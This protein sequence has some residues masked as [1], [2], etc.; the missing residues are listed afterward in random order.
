[1]LQTTDYMT[2]DYPITDYP[3]TALTPVRSLLGME[4]C[5]WLLAA[6]PNE[7]ERRRISY[8][9]LAVSFWYL[10]LY[11]QPN[12]AVDCGPVDCRLGRVL[13]FAPKLQTPDYQLP[14]TDLLIHLAAN[15]SI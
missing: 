11:D 6:L 2:T 3:I 9:Q 7:A 10:A 8:W 4:E 5:R 13:H 15:F 1:M 12:D 14:T